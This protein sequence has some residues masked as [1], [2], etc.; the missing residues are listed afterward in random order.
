MFQAAI[1]QMCSENN[2]ANNIKCLQKLICQAVSQGASYIQTPEMTGLVEKNKKSFFA[3]IYKEQED[4]IVKLAS[5]MAKEFSVFIHIGS[6]PIL[7][8]KGKAA[9]RSFIFS[10]QG[11]IIAKYDKLHMFDVDLDNGESWRESATYRAGNEVVVAKMLKAK[12]GLTICYDL[13]FACLYRHLARRGAEILCVPSCFTQQT[14]KAHWHI[15]NRARAIEN[16]AFVIAA[17]QGGKHKDGRETFGHSLIINPWGDI[18]CEIKNAKAG[19]A[20]ATIDIH[21]VKV[22][23]AKIPNLLKEINYDKI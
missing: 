9:N 13:R 20:L 12:F 4:P 16:G 8:G 10:P 3:K 18:I 22:A 2:F 23:R 14:G 17:A 1:I 11:K 21:Q 5:E 19:F 15:L 6:T 7:I